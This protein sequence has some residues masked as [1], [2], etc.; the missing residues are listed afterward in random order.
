MRE[1]SSP[2]TTFLSSLPDAAGLL[3]VEAHLPLVG[4][5][6]ALDREHV[7]AEV[8]PEQL[9]VLQGEGLLRLELEVGLVE[10]RGA[11]AASLGRRA[12]PRADSRASGATPAGAAGRRPRTRSARTSLAAD[13]GG[14]RLT[15][16]GGPAAAQLLA[17]AV[18]A[19]QRLDV[20]L[21]VV[22]VA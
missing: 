21:D 11:H 12:L 18:C 5:H 4:D 9:R 16:S 20:R 13:D 7:T 3:V 14:G 6:R 2:V 1:M 22:A 8:H 10:E 15:L 19:P 17:Y